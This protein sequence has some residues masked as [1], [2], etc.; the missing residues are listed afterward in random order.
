MLLAFGF[1]GLALFIIVVAAGILLARR[2]W[3]KPLSTL[4]L[5]AVLFVVVEAPR[6]LLDAHRGS[7]A[8]RLAYFWMAEGRVLYV[9]P[10]AVLPFAIARRLFGRAMGPRPA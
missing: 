4:A 2:M 5:V 6:L 7:L 1:L 9:L 10:L 8:L 3:A